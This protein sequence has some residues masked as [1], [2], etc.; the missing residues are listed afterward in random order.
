MKKFYA[1]AAAAMMAVSVNAQNGAPLYATGAGN[2]AGGEWSP[3]NASEFTYADGKYTL[4]ITNL[5]KLKIS[6]V[7]GDWG[8]FNG[9]ALLVHTAIHPVKQCL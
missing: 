3:E 5:S 8:T 6:T 4:E 1:I 9:G 7:K 2:F